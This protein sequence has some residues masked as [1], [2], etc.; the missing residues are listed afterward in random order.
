MLEAKT[1]CFIVSYI[2]KLVIIESKT[3]FFYFEL[4]L[5]LNDMSTFINKKELNIGL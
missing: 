1:T 2:F 3:T 5:L 4:L